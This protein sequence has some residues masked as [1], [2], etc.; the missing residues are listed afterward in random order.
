MMRFSRSEIRR[1]RR[2]GPATTRSMASS[3]SIMLT[4]FLP[5]RAVRSAPSLI[6][7]ARSAPPER[8]ALVE[9]HDG[10]GVVLGL[11]EQVPHAGPANADE[12]LDEV[13]AADGEERHPR[14]TRHRPRQQGLAS[15]WWPVQKDPLGD[16]GA[17]GL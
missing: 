10:G 12:P 4:A 2:S 3:S 14:L 17:H 15:P 8:I 6:T 11:L 5:R 7:L 16:L 9:G 1:V 13:R